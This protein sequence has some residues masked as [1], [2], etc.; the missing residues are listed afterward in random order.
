MKIKRKVLLLVASILLFCCSTMADSPAVPWSRAIPSGNGKYVLVL[1]SPSVKDQE[2]YEIQ[3]R[4][5]WRKG[6]IPAK[7]VPK[8]EKSLQKEIDREAAIREIYPESGLF[9]AGKSPKL[10]WKTDFYDLR[11]WVRVSDDSE[12]FI[13]GRTIVSPILEEKSVQGNPDVK[14]VVGKSPNMEDI[15]LTFYALGK[16]IRSFKASE[17]ISPYEELQTNTNNAFIWSEEG[18]LDDQ[19]KKIVITKKNGDKL[20]FAMNGDLISGRLP[21]QVTAPATEPV[22]NTI[23][24]E[25]DKRSACGSAFIFILALAVLFIR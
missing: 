16:L 22:A 18:L 17:L 12:H 25:Q 4:E 8:A 5:F 6:G 1:I 19:M 15:V 23:Q 20:V 2:E 10:L 24:S 13:T 21:D 3:S 14:E 11:A 9:T 7:D